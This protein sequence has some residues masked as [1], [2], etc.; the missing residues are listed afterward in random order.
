MSALVFTLHW[1]HILPDTHLAVLPWRCECR[2][3]SP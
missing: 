1:W 3:C 2:L